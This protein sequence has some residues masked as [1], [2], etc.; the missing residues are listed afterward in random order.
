MRA[1]FKMTD[2]FLSCQQIYPQITQVMDFFLFE[3]RQQS[4]NRS[5]KF[6]MYTFFPRLTCYVIITIA[7][8]TVLLRQREH[9]NRL[10]LKQL[11]IYT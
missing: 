2:I 8:F 3:S 4:D 1:T 9:Q 7:Y 11:E 5:D 10:L 6:V